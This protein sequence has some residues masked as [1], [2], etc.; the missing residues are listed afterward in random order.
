M[1]S[2]LLPFPPCHFSVSR[3]VHVWPANFVSFLV[4][5]PMGST[6]LLSLSLSPKPRRSN[7]TS[8]NDGSHIQAVRPFRPAL[9]TWTAPKVTLLNIYSSFTRV[10]L[11]IYV[12]RNRGFIVSGALTFITFVM[13]QNCI[14]YNIIILWLY[15]RTPRSTFL[16]LKK[17]YMKYQHWNNFI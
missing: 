3:R 17:S 6:V 5:I 8:G 4:R 14:F 13:W 9:S 15:I 12:P 1:Q 11:W 2:C 10:R 7:L 16:S